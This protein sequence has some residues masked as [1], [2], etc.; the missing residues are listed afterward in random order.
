MM[1]FYSESTCQMTWKCLLL[2]KVMA[3]KQRDFL[4]KYSIEDGG[5][6][7]WYSFDQFNSLLS[8]S[9][10]EMLANWWLRLD[11]KRENRNC[12]MLSMF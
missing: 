5:I 8:L 3:T 9:Q 7:V 12:V 6:Q 1:S 4:G 11:M 10:M 2:N